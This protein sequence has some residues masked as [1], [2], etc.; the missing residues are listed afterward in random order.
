ML[1]S[2]AAL[3]G[4]IN[5]GIGHY[6]NSRVLWMLNSWALISKLCKAVR[7]IL[8]LP[9][10]IGQRQSLF[11]FQYL[12]ISMWINVIKRL[13]VTKS[14]LLPIYF[15]YWR[16]QRLCSNRQQWNDDVCHIQVKHCAVSMSTRASWSTHA[17]KHRAH[18][19][20]LLPCRNCPFTRM[21]PVC[22]KKAIQRC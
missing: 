6:F 19:V 4:F 14:D 3:K 18:I 8:Q 17:L 7:Q 22:L 1:W 15:A 5:V 11:F 13:T 10:T 20:V 21:C 16:G 9:L 2:T 12:N